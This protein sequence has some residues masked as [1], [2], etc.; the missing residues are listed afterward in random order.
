MIYWDNAA[1]TWPKP[2]SVRAAVGQA[3]VRYGANP[4]RAG[5]D[6]AMATGQEVYTCREEL[7]EFFGLKD[8]TGVVF[9]LNCTAGLNTV[10]RGLLE[11]GGRALTSDLEHNAVRR[12]LAAL[13]ARYPR[14]DTA[15]WSPDEDETVEHFRRAIRPDTRLLVCTHASNVFGV[16]LPIRKLSRLAHDHGLLFCVDAAQSAG[17]LPVDMEADG[18]DYLCVAPHKGLYA[19]MGTGLLLCRER[20]KIPP[21]VRGGTGS[22]SVQAVQPPDLPDRLESGTPNTAGICGIRA[23][24]RF[25][26]EKGRERIYAHEIALLQ[27]VYDRLASHPGIRVYTPRPAVG[28]TAPVLSLNVVGLPSEQTAALL[29]EQGIAVRAGLHCAPLAHTRFGTL[30]QGTVRLAPSAFSTAEEAEKIGKVFSQIAKK[31]LHSEK[32]MV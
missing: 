18:I 11:E 20:D 19:P 3:L 8:P 22:Y 29:N 32:I 17:V 24:L 26:R 16:T 14:Y 31:S 25:V 23:G 13:S 5:H 27:R 15:A 28:R 21:L 30:P 6:M 9:T 4:G 2:A 12:P 1:T 7:A 10:I